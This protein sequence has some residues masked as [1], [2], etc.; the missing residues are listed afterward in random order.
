MNIENLRTHSAYTARSE[1]SHNDIVLRRKLPFHERTA[2]IMQLHIEWPRYIYCNLTIRH[3]AYA[4]E[5]EH[6]AMQIQ[7]IRYAATNRI[8]RETWSV[9]KPE[10]SARWKTISN[11]LRCASA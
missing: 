6:A 10:S 5:T 1:Y 9:T 3:S 7:C 2:A 11:S 4:L 8:R